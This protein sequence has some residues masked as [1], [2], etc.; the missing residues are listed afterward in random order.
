MDTVPP[1]KLVAFDLDGTLNRTDLFSVPAIQMVQ[2]KLGFPISTRETII[3]AYGTGY[4]EFMSIVFPSGNEQTARDYQRLIP[5]AE[6]QFLFKARPYEG[7]PELLAAL[8]ECGYQTAVCSNS[9]YRYISMALKA[10]GVWDLIDHIQELEKG[11]QTK[12]E[13]LACLLKKTQAQEAVMV[14]DTLFDYHAAQDNHVP[15]IGCGYGFRPYEM[16]P[17]S[18]VVSSPMEILP[19]VKKLL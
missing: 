8:H 14:G 13:S 4:Q 1:C 18:P 15:F 12:S 16:E 2:K 6:E 3:S 5:E 17:L 11:M 7:V 19:L 9:N 10:I